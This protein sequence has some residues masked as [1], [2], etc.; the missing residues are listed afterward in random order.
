MFARSAAGDLFLAVTT[1]F[2]ISVMNGEIGFWADPH[3]DILRG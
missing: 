2:L 1:M 3:G